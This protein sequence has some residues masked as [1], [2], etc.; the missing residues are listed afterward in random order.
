MLF[1]NKRGNPRLQVY[2]DNIYLEEKQSVT[3]L[4]VVIDNKLLWKDHI[5]L[6]CS[7]ISKSIGILRYLRYSYPT[8]ILRLLYMSLIFSY[9]NYCNVVWGSA[10]DSHL[11]PLIILQKKAVRVITNS[12]YDASSAPIFDSL[13]VLQLQKI[14]KLNCCIFMFKC[15]NTNNYPIHRNKTLQ[16][17]ATHN[18]ATRNRELFYVPRERLEICRKSFLN[19][20]ISL[21][22]DISTEVKSEKALHSFKTAIKNMLLEN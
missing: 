15:L 1:S 14:H 11:K 21:W 9:L 19:K 18:Y 2:A 20:G 4:G 17:T 6:V 5:K 10:Y 16:N 12:A 8:H 13:K 22:N 3:F 7:K